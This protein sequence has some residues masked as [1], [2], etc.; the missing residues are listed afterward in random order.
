MKHFC[1]N[2]WDEVLESAFDSE[3]Y[4]NL[5]NF[6]VG[7]YKNQ[8]IYPTMFN[9][10]NALKLTPPAKVKVVIIGQDPYINENQAHGLA[11]SVQDG[12]AKPPS[13]RNMFKEIKSDLGLEPPASGNLNYWAEQGVLLLNSVLTV[14]AGLSNSH[15]GKGWEDFT[16]A[17]VRALNELNQ[18]I[19]FMLWGRN[20]EDVYFKNVDEKATS[21]LILKA[22]HPS[23]L[24]ASRGFFGCKHF[25][26]ANEFL[27]AN[28]AAEIKWA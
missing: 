5:H 21:H 10:F 3:S 9:I 24:S 1:G 8:T 7:E 26:R 17:V 11:F 18:P 15:K 19:V 20:A 23:P 22:P 6:L 12:C 13:L 14:R 28:N 4:L 27:K 16:G 2:E 25:S